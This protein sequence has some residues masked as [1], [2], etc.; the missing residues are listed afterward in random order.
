MK[1]VITLNEVPVD[2]SIFPGGEIHVNLLDHDD[3]VDQMHVRAEIKDSDG[4]MALLMVKD[5]IDRIDCESSVLE[6]AYVPYSRQDRVC[7]EGDAFSLKVFANLI[8]SM[9]FDVVITIDNHSNVAGALINNCISVSQVDL[10]S[11]SG[12]VGDAILMGELLLV[13]PDAGAS[14]KVEEF[15]FEFVQCLKHRDPSTGVLSGFRVCDDVEGRDLL[16]VDDIC[17]GGGT[18]IGLTEEL[19]HCGARTVSLYVTH[20][21]FSKGVDVLYE[22]GIKDIYTYSGVFN[23][24]NNVIKLEKN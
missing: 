1:S 17:D 21:I 24:N 7:A 15:G 5:I 13:A 23:D 8:N 10:F 2:F 16:I 11:G 19:L 3:T 20:G 9:N 14:K 22:A 12:S 4:V 6:L 18:F